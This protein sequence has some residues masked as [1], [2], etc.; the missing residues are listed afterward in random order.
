MLANFFKKSP[1]VLVTQKEIS[2]PEQLKNKTIM[3]LS[4]N[5]DNIT[6][7]QMLN[8]FGI[9]PNDYKNIATD[10]SVKKFVAKEVDA[11][12]VFVTNE[13]YQLNKLSCAYNVF[14][15]AV[16]GVEYYDSNLFTSLK[17]IQ[18]HP[19]RAKKFTNATIK[20]WEYALCTKKR[21]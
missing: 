4:D 10:F 18:S 9:Q 11:M 19:K 5:I 21:L 7:L 20:G 17:E 15:P 1:L 13:T 6:L 2:S 8:K 3:G 12:S 16:F 14:D